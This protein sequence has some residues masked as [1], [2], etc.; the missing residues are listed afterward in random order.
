MGAVVPVEEPA[1]VRPG[2]LDVVEA[3]GELGA[4]FQRLEVR[5]FA[6]RVVSVR[7]RARW[8]APEAGREAPSALCWM[9]SRPP[10]HASSTTATSTGT[11]WR[12]PAGSAIAT[13]R[14][15]GDSAHPI[16]APLWTRLRGLPKLRAPRHNQSAD[17]PLTAAL[18][19]H[20]VASP[21]KPSWTSSYPIWRLLEPSSL[22][23]DQSAA[24]RRTSDPLD[25]ARPLRPSYPAHGPLRLRG[26][27]RL[28]H[29]R[30]HRRSDRCHSGSR[31][32]RIPS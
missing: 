15:H 19:S 31:A 1:A 23:G 27:H 8:C 12:S 25:G 20:G 6:P 21:K 2:V 30:C 13:Q 17:D 28:S 4:V 29:R 3:L 9:R 7:R 11:G 26:R 16:T 10:A 5:H 18:L 32:R 24:T 22:R 14:S